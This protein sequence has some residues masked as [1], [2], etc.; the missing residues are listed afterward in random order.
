MSNDEPRGETDEIR[1]AGSTVYVPWGRQQELYE[2][3]EAYPGGKPIV[4]RLRTSPD[5]FTEQ[6][7]PIVLG[8][9]EDWFEEVGYHSMGPYLMALRDGL[10]DDLQP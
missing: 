9:L 3:L 6:E 7:K 2:R 4:E 10:A 1:L 8:C 5:G